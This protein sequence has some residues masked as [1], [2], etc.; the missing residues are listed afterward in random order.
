MQKLGAF[1]AGPALIFGFLTEGLAGAATAVIA[2]IGVSSALAI[3]AKERG[4]GVEHWSQRVGGGV[5]AVTCLVAVLW[6]GWETGWLWGLGVT[7]R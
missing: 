7:E 2:V 5:A 4:S 1:L 3:A 6:G